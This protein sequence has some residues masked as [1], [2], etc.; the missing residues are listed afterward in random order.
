MPTYYY[1]FDLTQQTFA[2][3]STNG[4]VPASGY[5]VSEFDNDSRGDVRV[6]D[7][8]DLSSFGAND[9]DAFAEVLGYTSSARM[10]WISYESHTPKINKFLKA[11]SRAFY[12]TIGMGVADYDPTGGYHATNTI[13]TDPLRKLKVGSWSGTSKALV[14]FPDYEANGGHDTLVVNG[15]TTT[16]ISTNNRF[17]STDSNVLLSH[18]GST[19]IISDNG[20]TSTSSYDNDDVGSYVDPASTDLVWQ[21]SSSVTLPVAQGGGD[22]HIVT[23]SGT[24]YT[25]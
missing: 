20:N 19:W 7:W 4:T 16:W 3:A 14:Y 6:A 21:N 24:R 15:T 2:V 18:D 1:Q 17:E 25:L 5:D 13:T 22:P 8:S 10:G 11:T 12:G 9:F 23:F